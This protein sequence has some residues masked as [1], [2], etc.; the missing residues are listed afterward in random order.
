MS[1]PAAQH[2]STSPDPRPTDTDLARGPHAPTVLLG[3]VGL[4]VA[5][6]I[7]LLA[8]ARVSID[9]VATVPW[10]MLALG[11]ALVVAGLLGRRH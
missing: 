5:V 8:V 3:L 10:V 1:T 6:G 4:A 7:A 9:V 2:D 11:V